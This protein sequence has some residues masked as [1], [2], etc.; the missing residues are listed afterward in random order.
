[1][2]KKFTLDTRAGPEAAL[3]SGYT[4]CS[5]PHTPNTRQI[6]HQ[7]RNKD[8]ICSPDNLGAADAGRR[9]CRGVGIVG[10]AAR[11]LRPQRRRCAAEGFLLI[12]RGN[13]KKTVEHDPVVHVVSCAL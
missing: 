12:P 1:M 9:G 3:S 6:S 2:S 11:A 10:A 8:R 13:Q 5:S 4:R 7:Q